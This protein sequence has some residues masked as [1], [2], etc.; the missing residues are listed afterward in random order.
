MASSIGH[1]GITDNI[2]TYTIRKDTIIMSNGLYARH[3]SVLLRINDTTIRELRSSPASVAGTYTLVHPYR[4]QNN[5]MRFY[6]SIAR[7]RREHDSLQL[8]QRKKSR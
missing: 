1:A 8:Y 7:Y 5:G 2:G 4:M 6:D 3:D